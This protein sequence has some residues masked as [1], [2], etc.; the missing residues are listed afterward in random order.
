MPQQSSSGN[1]DGE[2]D[3][4]YEED[5]GKEGRLYWGDEKKERLGAPT[6]TTSLLL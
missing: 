2:V 6:P 3:D 4:D 1:G 5:V